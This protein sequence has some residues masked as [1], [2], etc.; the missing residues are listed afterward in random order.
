MGPFLRE[1]VADHKPRLVN[2]KPRFFQYQFPQQSTDHAWVEREA[3]SSV[4]DATN[5]LMVMGRMAPAESV[6]YLVDGLLPFGERAT[7]VGDLEAL[8]VLADTFVDMGTTE[9]AFGEA[10]NF[11]TRPL[12][13]SAEGA[14][15]ARENN[16]YDAE[17]LLAAVFFIL[18]AYLRYH[19]ER[20]SAAGWTYTSTLHET[21]AKRR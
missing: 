10:V 8:E 20:L 15:W 1:Y 14:A 12:E 4:R 9:A 18:F 19:I 6:H 17:R 5:A 16:H 13:R 21:K 7:E 2:R 11:N 3:C